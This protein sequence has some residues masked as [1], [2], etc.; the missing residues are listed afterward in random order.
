MIFKDHPKTYELLFGNIG[1]ALLAVRHAKVGALRV[2][3]VLA[4]FAPNGRLVFGN[5]FPADIAEL[6]FQMAPR[7]EAVRYWV[8]V[9]MMGFK[10]DLRK[11][12]I[13]R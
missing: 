9:M 1:C 4:D 12:K 8:L 5:S 13:R 11:M 6:A 7:R 3:A 2:D 10:V